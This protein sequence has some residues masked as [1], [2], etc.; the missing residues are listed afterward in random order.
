MVVVKENP[1][2]KPML[3]APLL[4]GVVPAPDKHPKPIIYSEKEADLLCRNDRKDIFEKGQKYS[5]IDNHKTP[6]SIFV[7]PGLAAIGAL[8]YKGLRHFKK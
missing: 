2:N 6:K 3:N 8:I 5:F 7:I 1:A 4:V